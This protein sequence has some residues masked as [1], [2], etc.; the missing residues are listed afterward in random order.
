VFGF[1]YYPRFK[2]GPQQ[3]Q[4]RK[5]STATESTSEASKIP[6]V[7]HWRSLEQEMAL[8]ETE[9]PELSATSDQPSDWLDLKSVYNLHTNY[10]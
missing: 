5:F 9:E 8:V 10:F 6:Y 3:Q 7:P 1:F 4:Q 2:P